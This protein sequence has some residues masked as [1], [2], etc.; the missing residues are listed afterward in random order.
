[1]RGRRHPGRNGLQ[2]F[3]VEAFADRSQVA[4]VLL[5]RGIAQEVAALLVV[6]QRAHLLVE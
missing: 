4:F 3:G 1:M 6:E 5:E 2:R